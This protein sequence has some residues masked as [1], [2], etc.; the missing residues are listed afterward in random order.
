M[1]KD[2]WYQYVQRVSSLLE[3]VS[4]HGADGENIEVL[5]G[6]D[7]WRD[8]TLQVRLSKGT[9][10]LIGNGASA[11]MASHTAADLAK[12][13][14]IHTQVFTDVALMTA[15]SNDI[16]YEAVFSE[17]LRR[18]ASPGDMLVAV[19][20][21][22]RS[23]NLMSATA[24]AGDMGMTVVTLTAADANNPLRAQGQLNVYVPARTYGE[25][26][27]CHAALLHH[28]MDL[29]DLEHYTFPINMMPESASN[30]SSEDQ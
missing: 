23:A 18:M 1:G 22:G 10:Y 24:L 8:K 13:A 16:G 26:E 28:W 5:E 21:S 27:T 11:A 30:V 2:D 3:H 20:S 6:F 14:H 12:N 25:A 4:F 17:P 29:V 19:S 15:I 7:I 9:I